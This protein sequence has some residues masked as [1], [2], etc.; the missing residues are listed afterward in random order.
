M[1]VLTLLLAFFSVTN[2]AANYLRSDAGN[3]RRVYRGQQYRLEGNGTKRYFWDAYGNPITPEEYD[4]QKGKT[5]SSTHNN[6]GTTYST[7][8]NHGPSYTTINNYGDSYLTVNNYGRGRTTVNDH[9]DSQT[10]V[11]RNSSSL[12]DREREEILTRI[13]KKLGLR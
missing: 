13:E 5:T 2:F 12:S 4:R 1:K 6:Y 11:N 8:N 10:T 3:I 9:G 7:T